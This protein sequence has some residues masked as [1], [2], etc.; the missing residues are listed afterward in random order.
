MVPQSLLR[1]FAAAGTERLVAYDKAT[2]RS[3]PLSVEDAGAERDFYSVEVHGRRFSWEPAF[4]RL[5]DALAECLRDIAQVEPGGNTTGFRDG[6]PLLVATQLLRTRLQRTTAEELA[7]QIRDLTAAWG[8]T[9]P[10][11][12]DAASRLQHLHHLVNIG[13]RRRHLGVK[14]LPIASNGLP[15]SACTASSG[16]EA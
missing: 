8:A 10:T 12:T 6:L 15:Y 11:L 14:G 5:D 1:R 7:I 13:R 9:V 3:F 2:R 16:L 4:Q